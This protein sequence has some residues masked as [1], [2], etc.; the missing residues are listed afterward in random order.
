MKNKI[1]AFVFNIF[2]RLFKLDNSLITF[3]DKLD[4]HF[5][6]NLYEIKNE[7][8]KRNQGYTFHIIYANDIRPN[9]HKLFKYIKLF[10]VHNYYLAKSK[11]IFLNDNFIP[12]EHMNFKNDVIITQVWHALG[13]FKKS[14]MPILQNEKEKQSLINSNKKIKVL[15]CSSEKIKEIYSMAFGV[16][17][18]TVKV[19]GMPQIDYYFKDHDIQSIRDNFNQLY[20]D[21]KNKKIILYAPTFRDDIE[22]DKELVRNI[23]FNKISKELND[24]YCFVL[25][26][27]PV[28]RHADTNNIGIVD[29]TNYPSIR[30]LL[31]LSDIL[32]TD[33]S[34][35]LIEYSLLKKPIIIY[36]ND[37]DEF[38]SKRG[39]YYDYYETVPGPICKT[40]DELIDTIRTNKFDMNKVDK[41]VH[42]HNDFFDD[43]STKRIVDYVLS[44]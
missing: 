41:F 38:I 8:M 6:G 26:L 39:F 22:K 23:D 35:L 34:S 4:T 13:A 24:E 14:G 11:Y 29:A 42:M 20:P 32:I 27:H 36:A 7:I 16:E 12:M 28:V 37:I 21:A 18:D 44:L 25:R 33:Y 30:E 17:N 40:T 31:L 2:N 10:T 1:F 5:S 19:L 43:Q 3:V 9:K 15:C